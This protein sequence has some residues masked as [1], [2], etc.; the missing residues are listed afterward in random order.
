MMLAI[1][2]AALQVCLKQNVEEGMYIFNDDM[3]INLLGGF[4]TFLFS[5]KTF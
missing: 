2:S 5:V 3:S 4:F 1:R